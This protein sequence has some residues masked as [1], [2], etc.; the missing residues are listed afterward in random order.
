MRE[1][2]VEADLAQR[3]SISFS[4]RFNTVK[5]DESVSQD[6]RLYYYL[7][8]INKKKTNTSICHDSAWPNRKVGTAASFLAHRFYLSVWLLCEEFYAEAVSKYI[9]VGPA[10]E[11]WGQG[12][13]LMYEMLPVKIFHHRQWIKNK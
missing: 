2:M 6:T 5:R 12:Y 13:E 3:V 7:L 11:R 4:F 8:D 9:Q 1:T 10:Q